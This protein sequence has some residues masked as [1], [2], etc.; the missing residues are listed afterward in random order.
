M[1]FFQFDLAL[2]LL[3]GCHLAAASRG[4]NLVNRLFFRFL[5]CL[6]VGGCLVAVGRWGVLVEGGREDEAWDVFG[7]VVRCYESHFW[8]FVVCYYWLSWKL[9]KAKALVVG[10]NSV[11]HWGNGFLMRT[12]RIHGLPHLVHLINDLFYLDIAHWFSINWIF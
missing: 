12:A 3:W 2:R 10:A 1:R 5:G 6:L 8:D 9:S 11:M 7:V 4:A